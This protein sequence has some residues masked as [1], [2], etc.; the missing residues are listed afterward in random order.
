MISCVFFNGYLKKGN[1]RKA[2]CLPLTV[3]SSFPPL[4][5]LISNANG[6]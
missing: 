4:K 1:P 3:A 2:H 5:S 6:F